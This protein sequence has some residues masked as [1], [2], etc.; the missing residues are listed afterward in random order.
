MA[1]FSR[2]TNVKWD[3]GLMDGKGTAEAGTGAFSLPVSF[4]SRVGEPAGT[5]SPEE[6]IAG[7]REGWK[8]A[9]RDAADAALEALTREVNAQEKRGNR[10]D[11]GVE[12]S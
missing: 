10:P 1:Q 3:G 7:F 8:E 4:P 12:P 11:S 9:T 2:S 5:T 6:F